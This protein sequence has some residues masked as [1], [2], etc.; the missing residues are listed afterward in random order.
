MGFDGN[1]ATSK[2][3][4]LHT[5]GYVKKKKRKVEGIDHSAMAQGY[6][7]MGKENLE[8]VN[9]FHASES[10]AHVTVSKLIGTDEN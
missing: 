1:N 5:G 7:D 9:A 10:Q 2:V 8:Q 6:M 4:A 3:T